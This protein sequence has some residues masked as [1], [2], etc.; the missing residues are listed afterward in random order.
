MARLYS[1]RAVGLSA[2]AASLGALVVSM[3]QL[4]ANYSLPRFL[5]VSKR[6]AAVINT[7]L[8]S[9][10]VAASLGAAVV[11]L[12]P[13]SSKLAVLGPLFAGAFLLATLVQSA[14]ALLG[15]VLVAERSATTLAKANIVPNLVK[16]AAPAMFAFLGSFGAYVAR[17]ASDVVASA[18]LGVI[19]K[20]RGH[21]FRPMLDRSSIREL[22]RFSFGMYVAGIIGGL[23][24]M[25]LPVIVLA[26]FGSSQAA[27]WSVGITMAMLLYQLPTMVGQAL[28]PEVVHRRSERQY[29]LRR[30]ALLTGAIVVPVLLVAYFAAPLGLQILGAHY[31]AGSLATL[32][33]L[34]ISG[35]VTIMNYPAGVV[36]A[37]ARKTLAISVAN[38]VNV[39]IVLGL[40]LSW[41]RNAEGVAFSWLIGDIA[42]TVLF[43]CLAVMALHQVGGS[44]AAVGSDAVEPP[45]GVLMPVPTFESQARGLQ[46]LYALAQSQ[47]EG[48]VGDR[49]GAGF[50]A[51][52]V[53]GPR[54]PWHGN[55]S[56][57]PGGPDAP[58]TRLTRWRSGDR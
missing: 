24:L 57:G 54:D 23:P 40:A 37:L 34:I 48:A 50:Q 17:F 47:Q 38:V 19:V 8:T 6:P 33:L 56:A 27:Y 41:A 10:L 32:R 45:P 7:A 30:S 16:L 58:R 22:R 55:Q 9:A 3:T 15:T 28:L 43:C 4:G 11:L 52:R 20:R 25:A 5:P 46:M 39:I 51:R 18:T 13:V 36:L 1:V 44:W 49:T 53:P 42:N 31:V 21:R 12:S 2:T 26:R 29:L 14:E 35:F